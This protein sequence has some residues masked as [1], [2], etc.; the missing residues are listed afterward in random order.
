MKGEKRLKKR[1]IVLNYF[2]NYAI[3]LRQNMVEDNMGKRMYVCVCV[4]VCVCVYFKKTGSL[5]CTGEVGT[6]L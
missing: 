6:T 4:C 5:C 3:S 1:G 2:Q